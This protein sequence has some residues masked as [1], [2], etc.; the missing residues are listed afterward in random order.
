MKKIDYYE[1]EI[2]FNIHMLK[3]ILIEVLSLL[4]FNIFF[5]KE[6]I[7]KSFLTFF[8]VLSG[9]FSCKDLMI[10]L[11]KT[12]TCLF[13]DSI[14]FVLNFITYKLRNLIQIPNKRYDYCIVTLM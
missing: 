4:L 9:V 11:L 7:R 13:F 8:L 6:N 3:M 1:R 2:N 12:L 5:S 14:R 10:K